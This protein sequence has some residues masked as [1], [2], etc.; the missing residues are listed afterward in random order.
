[1]IEFF[2]ER[3]ITLRNPYIPTP[4]IKEGVTTTVSGTLK[5][6]V[7]SRQ[8]VPMKL[9]VGDVCLFEME[10]IHTYHRYTLP[11]HIKFKILRSTIEY[12]VKCRSHTD[13]KIDLQ[14]KFITNLLE[15]MR[16]EYTLDF[17]GDI[18]QIKI[19]VGKI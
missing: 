9:M 19:M 17:K 11:K 18:P 14:K 13:H 7:E 4:E 10:V 3:V 12:L 16:V 8:D 15:R 2:L 1:M 5:N 6:P